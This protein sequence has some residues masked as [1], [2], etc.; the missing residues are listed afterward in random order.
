MLLSGMD[1]LLF[2]GFGGK[3]VIALY[4]DRCIV[5]WLGQSRIV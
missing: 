3:G 1:T 4:P 5:L 2:G